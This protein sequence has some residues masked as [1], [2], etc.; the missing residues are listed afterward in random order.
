MRADD[1]RVIKTKAALRSAMGTLL[2]KKD[3]AQVS[4]G[5]ILEESGVRKATFYTHYMD[6]YDLFRD[7]ERERSISMF[8]QEWKRG[9]LGEGEA[10]AANLSNIIRLAIKEYPEDP[11]A[12][13]ED[14]Q[15]NRRRDFK[16]VGLQ[17]ALYEFFLA[18]DRKGSVP[19]NR[20]FAMMA[21]Q[22]VIDASMI[23]HTREF[24]SEDE[25]N[26]FVDSA[27]QAIAKGEDGGTWTIY[28]GN[29]PQVSSC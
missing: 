5:E 8:E 17:N 3:L 29:R 26:R 7:F 21:T 28:A 19:E 22:I 15:Q 14:T 9:G 2:E 13:S 1:P 24:K 10:F 12:Q 11:F 4:I 23:A 18:L 27:G 25:L 20:F 6:K 16:I